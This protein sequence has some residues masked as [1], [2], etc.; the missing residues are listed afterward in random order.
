M[1][2]VSDQINLGDGAGEDTGLEPYVLGLVEF[3]Y[4]DKEG[5]RSAINCSTR[6]S[7]SIEGGWGA[8]KSAFLD[9]LKVVLR[10]R[11]TAVIEFEP[12][13]HDGSDELWKALASKF[14]KGMRDHLGRRVYFW[15]MLK[16]RF[17][18]L[19]CFGNNSK[20][21]VY[22]RSL[23]GI[24]FVSVVLAV[25]GVY[26]NDVYLAMSDV[27]LFKGVMSRP[28]V[29]FIASAVSGILG[30][31][32]L[33]VVWGWFRFGEGEL[34]FV[35]KLEGDF[36]DLVKAL[37][38]E[39]VDAD[40]QLRNRAVIIID[41]IDRCLELGVRETFRSL[42]VLLNDR[43]NV[44]L[45]FSMDR[46]RVAEALAIDGKKLKGLPRVE[47]QRYLEKFIHVT[48]RM[49][50]FGEHNARRLIHK[51]MGMS[52]GF[53]KG[54]AKIDREFVGESNKLIDKR[55]TKVIR[56]LDG[57]PRR[58]LVWRNEVY[59]RLLTLNALG[60]LGNED[61]VESHLVTVDQV[62]CFELVLMEWPELLDDLRRAPNLFKWLAYFQVSGEITED[63]EIIYNENLGEKPDSIGGKK[64]QVILDKWI[65]V[66][67]D[68]VSI[69]D[70]FGYRFSDENS[71]SP[72]LFS[73]LN[74]SLLLMRQEV[75]TEEELEV[76]RKLEADR[77]LEEL[78]LQRVAEVT[79]ERAKAEEEKAGK[80]KIA[81]EKAA[82][83][84]K[85]RRKKRKKGGP[86]KPGGGGGG[87]AKPSKVTTDFK[88]I[89]KP[90]VV[91][92]KPSV[93]KLVVP[94]DVGLKG[95]GVDGLGIQVGEGSGV[96]NVGRD[97]KLKEFLIEVGD[98][99][100]SGEVEEVSRDE[101]SLLK[102][103][104]K[105]QSEMN[106]HKKRMKKAA[107]R[108]GVE[109]VEYADRVEKYAKTLY[110]WNDFDGA[111][112]HFK[113]VYGIRVKT[114]GKNHPDVAVSQNDL[115][116]VLLSKGEK[117][118]GID[119]IEQSIHH[120][121]KTFGKGHRKVLKTEALLDEMLGKKKVQKKINKDDA[122]FLEE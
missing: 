97:D 21:L 75:V 119:F 78:T 64:N 61:M 33:G 90:V 110:K 73:V 100:G 37:C 76:D 44:Y 53:Q 8:G 95:V 67:I 1:A 42:S 114:L 56:I 120:D 22:H 3:L 55:I 35:S 117:N 11:E 94:K 6:R 38:P 115:G 4:P 106:W 105:Y 57:N 47:R 29:L 49:P 89:G 80:D 108:F 32:Y 93:R 112:K 60:R 88:K 7:V 62:V 84:K 72:L 18:K 103:N 54:I 40:E 79:A 96:L 19:F 13:V 113:N 71:S 109:S 12:W 25:L 107:D 27:A 70:V 10:E 68:D 39:S 101:M 51:V 5:D 50:S 118:I 2:N 36:S 23:G 116:K 17:R 45:L 92:I 14:H 69:S 26:A 48:M 91:G 52:G 81:K 77:L 104:D 46:N 102:Q 82:A 98:L 30:W 16:L 65:R 58:V 85:S 86:D 34:P 15:R 20:K 99:K 121:M 24:V 122:K 9:E 43:T 31:K 74:V 59:L 111:F 66:L 63:D 28:E 83:A 87:G 41:D